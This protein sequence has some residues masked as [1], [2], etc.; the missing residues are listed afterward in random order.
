MV[1]AV[2]VVGMMKVPAD[3]IVEVVAVRYALVAARRAVNVAMIV[4]LTVVI[5]RARTRIK[6]ANGD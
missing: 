2:A 6:V 1:V 5:R 4:A 3:K